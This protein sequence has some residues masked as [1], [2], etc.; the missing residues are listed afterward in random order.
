MRA[1]PLLAALSLGCG[2]TI[3]LPPPAS[4]S[5]VTTPTDQGAVASDAPTTATGDV[6][7]VVDSGLPS[8]DGRWRVS[9]LEFTGEDGARHTITDVDSPI[10]DGTGGTLPARANG[11]MHVADDRLALT[12]GVLANSHFYTYEP[13]GYSAAGFGAAGLLDQAS[14]RFTIVGSP[15][16]VLLE[17]NADGTVSLS[18]DAFGTSRFTYARAPAS[19][20]VN[21][22]STVGVAMIRETMPE[23]PAANLR[24]A[25]FWDRPGVATFAETNGVAVHFAG[26]FATY[27]VVLAG[28]PPADALGR[29]GV[30]TVALA[31]V[32]LY[33]DQ[34]GS[35][36]FDRSVDR[37]VA[38]SP[39]G[40]A[41]RDDTA[42]TDATNTPV[43]DLRPGYQYVHVH[44]DSGL[45][46]AAVTPFDNSNLVA[47]D[48][49]VSVAASASQMAQD[50][51]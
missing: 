22:I 41:W 2:S 14:G 42:A 50:V 40:I 12:A 45:G 49:P 51:L 25:L 29:V 17:R 27:P 10:P 28:P 43:R 48:L 31:R 38:I 16:S 9:Q 8:L 18:G 39:V 24:V 36:T 47:P 1:L 13:N 15:V 33:V 32:A 19:V 4:D 34:D 7:A 20:T 5:G 37:G 6:S 46:R 30:A 23:V 11:V 35:M 44:D 21:Q 3:I 26:R